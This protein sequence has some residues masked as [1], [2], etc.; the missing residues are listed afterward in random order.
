VS[1]V[2]DFANRSA[3]VVIPKEPFKAWAATYNEETVEVLHEYVNEKRIYLIEFFCKDNIR[4]II[5][6]YCDEIF[7][8]ELSTWNY[9]ENEWPKDRNVDVFLEWFDVSLTNGIYDLEN[10]DIQL[11]EVD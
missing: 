11:E 6:R 10:D 2:R 3:L 5:I 9:I 1:I 8:N 4:D 7:T